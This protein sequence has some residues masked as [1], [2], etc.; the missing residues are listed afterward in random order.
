M[1]LCA[2]EVLALSGSSRSKISAPPG[3]SAPAR[4][5]PPGFSSGFPSQDGLNPPPGFSS[6]ISSLEVSKTPP[7][8]TSPFSSGLSSQDG[9]N[10]PSRTFSAFSSGLSLQDGPNHPSRFPSAFT[11]GFSSR[12]GSNQ[13]YGSMYPGLFTFS[14]SL[15]AFSLKTSSTSYTFLWF[16]TETLLW[17]NALGRN[18]SHYQVPFGRHTN[19]IEFNDPA[20]LAVGKGRM[21]G[22]GD[23]GLE[24]ENT[25]AFPAHLQTSNNDP[26][27]QL[28]MQP[29]VQ[30]HQNLRFTDHT[31]D[32]FNPMN[33]NYLRSRFLQQSHGHVSPYAQMPQQPRNSQHTNGRLDGR[34]DLRQGNNTLM[35]D[36]SRMLYPSD[37]NNLHMLGSN[38]IYTRAFGM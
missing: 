15:F 3:F 26:R 33:D 11:S 14:I 2:Y 1:K 18:S 35:P 21:P 13:V 16:L 37:A 12:D 8:L 22:I 25:H 30:S 5:P 20:I 6:G 27:F 10:P 7:R 32:A 38:D 17:D 19:D 9:P 36:M 4:V 29:N 34:S 23:S 24:M 28:Q 31:Q